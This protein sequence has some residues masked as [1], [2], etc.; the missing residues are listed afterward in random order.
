MTHSGSET[1]WDYYISYVL[2]WIAGCYRRGFKDGHFRRHDPESRAVA[3]LTAMEGMAGYVALSQIFT[4]KKAAAHF[5]R[6]FIDEMRLG[7]SS[8]P[9]KRR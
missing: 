8:V 4:W 9:K 7:N 5:E 1:D 6:I 3:L 2:D